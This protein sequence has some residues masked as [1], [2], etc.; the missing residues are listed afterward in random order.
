[1][2]I[3]GYQIIEN[4][5]VKILKS[6]YFNYYFNKE[7]GFHAQWGRTKEDN[8]P[9][10]EFGP[11][12]ADIEI[13]NMCKGPNGRLCSF[14]YKSNNP[15]GTYTTLEDYKTILSKLPNTLTQVALG[16]DADASLNPDLF[17]ILEHTRN[18]G[19]I[20]NLT[21]ADI[22]KETAQKLAKVVGAVAVSFYPQAG[23]DCC[24]DSVKLLTD[25]IGKKGNTLQTVNI[26]YMVSKETIIHKD[27]LVLDLLNDPRLKGVT[28]TVLLSLKT[29]G[30]GV[31][32]E[33]LSKDEFKEVVDLFM[34]NGLGVGADSCSASKF[35][36]AIKGHPREK[37]FLDMIEGCESFSQS[38]YVNEGGIVYPCSFME[39][40]AWD[41]N[42]FESN[43]FSWN[44]LD[45]SIKDADDF[46]DTVWN[47]IEAKRFSVN[48]MICD[49]CDIGCQFYEI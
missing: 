27:E 40:N 13:L 43:E 2:K 37:Q 5:K 41:N 9:R 16:I 15:S 45:N 39:G 19:I 46:T 7:T 8:P 14:C 11:V 4:D 3:K 47:S 35:R 10:C 21:V 28:A 25:E 23:K 49:G 33:Q 1:V 18:Q 12:I 42:G 17:K 24:Y 6:E 36:Y 48:A 26:H 31:K 22:T 44:L 38:I 29:K 20:P 32:F 34:Q 30:R